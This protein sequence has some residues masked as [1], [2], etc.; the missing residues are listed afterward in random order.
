M[1]MIPIELSIVELN[2]VEGGTLYVR[3]VDMIDGTPLLDIKPHVPEFDSPPDVRIG[4]L[5]EARKTVANRASDNR[6]VQGGEWFIGEDTQGGT[7]TPPK[8]QPFGGE[9][10]MTRYSVPGNGMGL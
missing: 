5:A 4:W 2:R 6:F 8:G 10:I 7:P 1:E 9:S 3:N